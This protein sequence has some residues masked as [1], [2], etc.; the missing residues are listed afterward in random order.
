MSARVLTCLCFEFEWIVHLILK[1]CFIYSSLCLSVSIPPRVCVCL[2][3][4][5]YVCLY[6]WL[7]VL[8][9]CICVYIEDK[10][11]FVEIGSPLSSCS[12]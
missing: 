3:I 6:V 4:F 8:Y 7:C 1:I 12:F 9:E 11:Q 2:C 10:G 5:L